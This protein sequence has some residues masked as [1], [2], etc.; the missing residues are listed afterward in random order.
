MYFYI[1]INQKTSWS[2]ISGT[3]NERLQEAIDA[4]MMHCV[5]Q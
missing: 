5:A 4:V 2:E 1:L 3:Y